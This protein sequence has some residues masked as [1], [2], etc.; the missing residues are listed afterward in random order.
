[1][2]RT[3]FS[4]LLVSLV[5]AATATASSSSL[6]GTYKVTITGKPAPLDGKWRLVFLSRGVVH[7]VRNGKLV[8]VGKAVR[9]GAKRI[10][11]SDRSG[12]YACEPAAGKG[13]YVYAVARRRLTFTAVKDKCVGRKLI[14]TTKPFVR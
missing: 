8:V 6:G 12:S 9:V 1:V 11:F 2:K 3:A 14:L 7:T 13:T 10:A 5:L 4:L